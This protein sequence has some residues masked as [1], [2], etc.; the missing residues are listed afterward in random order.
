MVNPDEI[1]R[2][3][4]SGIMSKIVEEKKERIISCLKEDIIG[5][6]TSKEISGK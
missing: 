2:L 6:E 4:E 1:A 3:N 5:L